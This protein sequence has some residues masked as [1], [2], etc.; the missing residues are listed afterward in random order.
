M[1]RVSRGRWRRAAAGLIA[2]I[3]IVAVASGCVPPLAAA[4]VVME[5][6]GMV[7]I[8]PVG[9]VLRMDHPPHPGLIVGPHTAARLAQ[10]AVVDRISVGSATHV[11]RA[12]E[13]FLV[14][15][16]AG[17]ESDIY[18]G[19]SVP[20]AEPGSAGTATGAKPRLI[21]AGRPRPL[22]ALPSASW[23]PGRLPTGTFAL[24]VSVPRGQTVSLE[25][26]DVGRTQRLDLRTGARSGDPV[27]APLYRSRNFATTGR[28]V[29]ATV[30]DEEGGGARREQVRAIAAEAAL[31]PYDP[32]RKFA[33]VGAA[34]LALHL[35][36]FADI[37]LP[38]AW[39]H[40]VF[41][42]V[43]EGERPVRGQLIGSF[44]D[45]YA[46]FPVS[47]AFTTGMITIR[48][49]GTVAGLTGATLKPAIVHTVPV[50]IPAS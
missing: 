35:S 29:G 12:G 38:I 3:G 8:L 42:L 19:V 20:G 14:A 24:V 49:R 9:D 34:W 41:T 7:S 6:P 48:W 23:T 43:P 26:R 21:V 11:A 10:R 5:P 36:D 40:D 32:V 45:R 22:P 44:S 30:S 18:P 17:G 33:P 16:F 31:L 15:R 50:T 27:F 47:S 4:Q 39:A 1:R 28:S 25:I 2:G 46:L 37:R 13:E